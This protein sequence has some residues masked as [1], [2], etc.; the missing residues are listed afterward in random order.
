MLRSLVFLALT[1]AAFGAEPALKLTSAHMQK[2]NPLL[3]K[4]EPELWRKLL[5]AEQALKN[6]GIAEKAKKEFLEIAA[7]L[8]SLHKL[9]RKEDKIILGGI[10]WNQTDKT[11]EIPASVLYPNPGMPLEVLLCQKKG[12][13]HETLFTTPSRPL[14]LEVL[15]HMAGF[16]VGDSL[17]IEVNSSTE[18]KRI[19]DFLTWKDKDRSPLLWKFTGSEFGEVYI[20]DN[21]GEQIII[22]SRNE[23]VMQIENADFTSLKTPLY[24]Q[25]IKSYPKGMKVTLILKRFKKPSA[26]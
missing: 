2:Y 19:E 7:Q 3:P 25:N 11:I 15:L 20:P 13:V 21:A 8:T 1:F 9:E 12:R 16:K 14:H 10:T 18:S 5:T 22:W 23:A 6:S 17:T 4:L 24:S 26:K